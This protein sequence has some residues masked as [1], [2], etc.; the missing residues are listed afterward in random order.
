MSLARAFTKKVKRPEPS[1]VMPARENSVR[2]A[3]GTI[4]RD[5]ISLPT[6]L[7][8]TTN[9]LAY[10]APDLK[11]LNSAS[12]SSSLNSAGSG[13]DSDFSALAKSFF[14]SSATTPDT[15]VENSPIAPEPQK[16]YFDSLPKRS[17]TT[18]G[19]RSSSASSQ[20]DVPALPQRALSH[21]KKAHQSLAHKR[22]LSRLSPPPTSIPNIPVVRDSAAIF[23]SHVDANHPFGSELQQVNEVAEEFGA[24][25][26]LDEEEQMM[27]SKGLRKF[28]VEDYMMEIQ[29][30]YG[31]AFT[32]RF[33]PPLPT[34]WI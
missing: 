6:E 31:G 18:A 4:K 32:D 25:A 24:A 11:T 28:G 22:S 9:V 15:S 13:S 7:L 33:V 26:V 16:T 10:T 3:P 1:P 23:S 27:R 5:E 29:D 2:Y 17:A 12:S 19:S 20:P 34:A 30:L 8:S 21:S 14:N